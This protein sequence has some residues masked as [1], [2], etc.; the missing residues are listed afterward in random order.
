MEAADEYIR[1]QEKHHGIRT[2]RDVQLTFSQTAASGD[3]KGNVSA[4]YLIYKIRRLAYVGIFI[5]LSVLV[6]CSSLNVIH[7]NS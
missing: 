4:P 5:A 1:N 2:I 7:R 3:Y 6:F